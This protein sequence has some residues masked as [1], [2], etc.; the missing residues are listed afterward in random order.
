MDYKNID[1]IDA[2]VLTAAY[3]DF[4]GEINC[5]NYDKLKLYLTID[6]NDSENISIKALA[7]LEEGATEEYDLPSVSS[8][9]VD[10]LA[11]EINYDTDGYQ[12]LDFDLTGV[13]RIQLQ[14]I[15]GTLG[16]TPGQV[17]AEGV[18]TRSINL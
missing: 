6:A 11:Y 14:I 13:K 9:A 16:D 8:G 17:S 7:K 12:C 10:K 18:L 1:S 15:A 4:G 5:L 2:Q 3:A